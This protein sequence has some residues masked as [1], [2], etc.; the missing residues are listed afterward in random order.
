MVWM[1]AAA[2]AAGI[3]RDPRIAVCALFLLLACARRRAGSRTEA[4]WLCVSGVLFFLYGWFWIAAFRADVERVRSE[5]SQWSER[6]R[7]EGWVCRFP[8]YRYGGLA[9]EF[10]TRVD[11]VECTVLVQTK[12][13]VV[14]YGDSLRLAGVWKKPTEGSEEAYARRLLGIGVCGEFRA[15]ADGVERPGGVGGSWIGREVLFPCHDRVRRELGQSLGSR[16]GIP[17]ALLLGETGYLDNRAKEAFRALGVTHLLALSGWN[18]SLVAGALVA[19]LRLL[20]KRS[21]AAVLAAL[22]LYVAIVGFIV[23]LYRALVMAMVIIVASVFKRPLDPVGALARAFV[24][25]VLVYPNTLFSVAFQLSFMATLAVMLCVRIL[26]PPES[27]SFAAR[28]FFSIRSSL[29]VSLAAQLFVTPI[30][31]HYFGSMSLMSPVATLVFVLPIAFVLI[32][33][34]VTVFASI[35]VPAAGG[36][37]FAG[38]DRASTLFQ[39]AL[40]ASA[41]KVPGTLSLAAPDPWVF[42]G[43]LTLY[44]LARGRRSRKAA[45]ISLVVLSFVIGIIRQRLF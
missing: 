17:I 2:L 25:V 31:L 9:F 39:A 45:G 11:G 38:L 42:Y 27:K 14:E 36:L 32:Y 6:S 10:R 30:I 35:V 4:V 33:S 1:L 41:E 22:V 26:R 7:L 12:E 3:T 28:L 40:V 8:Y 23:S 19:F 16:T 29:V 24:I 20:R 34:A 43:G 37:L 18:L 21:S 13:F 5:S 15:A 44:V